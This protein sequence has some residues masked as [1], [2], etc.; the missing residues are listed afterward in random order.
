MSMT[1]IERVCMR[2]FIIIKVSHGCPGEVLSVFIA[3]LVR[4]H[5]SAQ[6][7]VTQR[8]AE[9]L[10]ISPSNGAPHIHVTRNAN[11]ERSSVRQNRAMSAPPIPH[12]RLIC[13]LSAG[14]R[15]HCPI[16]TS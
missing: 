16:S 5:S 12:V 4:F 13:T 14:G 11:A 1:H 10:W 7:A 6:R 8:R 15:M 9:I 3:H 2:I